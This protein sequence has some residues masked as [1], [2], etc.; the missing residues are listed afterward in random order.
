MLNNSNISVIIIYVQ[1]ANT[2]KSKVSISPSTDG[3]LHFIRVPFVAVVVV[4]RWFKCLTISRTGGAQHLRGVWNIQK[5]YAYIDSN[6]D[7][8]LHSGGD[9]VAVH[10]V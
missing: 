9:F 3:V 10:L 5:Q 7:M 4:V 1:S 6:R 2:M 8:L